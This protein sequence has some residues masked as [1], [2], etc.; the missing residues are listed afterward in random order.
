MLVLVTMLTPLFVLVVAVVGVRIATVRHLMSVHKYSN[1]TVPL[2]VRLVYGESG[3]ITPE[4]TAFLCVD[5]M[6]TVARL[7]GGNPRKS[8]TEAKV[9]R[10]K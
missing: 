3:P 9:T 7:G 5:W 10:V 8:V 6:V 1:G 2:V 4:S